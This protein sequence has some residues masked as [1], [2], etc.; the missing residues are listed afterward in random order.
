MRGIE[1]GGLVWHDSVQ[2]DERT[3]RRALDTFASRQEAATHAPPARRHTPAAPRSAEPRSRLSVVTTVT[4]LVLLVV[5]GVTVSSAVDASPTDGCAPI[6][7]TIAGQPTPEV[8]A[9]MVAALDEV[10][11]RTGLHFEAAPTGATAAELRI[12]WTPDYAATRAGQLQH[13][14]E[15]RRVLGSGRGLWG[16]DSVGRRVLVAGWVVVD[17]SHPWP[18]GQERDNALGGVLLHELGHVLRLTHST[19]PASYMHDYAAGEA[20]TWTVSD[21]AALAAVG[22]EAGCTLR[23]NVTTELPVN[24]DA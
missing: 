19:D 2:R 7:W 12:E 6:R 20:A 22:R 9:E 16:Y 24:A 11:R 4:V 13:A 18:L 3:V 1:G 15:S 14:T 10:G 5:A 17:A 23:T 8:A 21:L